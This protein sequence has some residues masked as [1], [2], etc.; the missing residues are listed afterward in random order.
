[1]PEVRVYTTRFCGYCIAAK[2]LLRA[3]GIEYV[4][5]DVTGDATSRAWLVESTGRRTVPQIFVG[6]KPIGGYQELAE[7]DRSGRLAAMLQE[8]AGDIERLA[9][10]PREP[11]ER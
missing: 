9:E 6:A 10:R 11:P 3:R 2:R 8:P 5:M 7:L 1:M 4:E